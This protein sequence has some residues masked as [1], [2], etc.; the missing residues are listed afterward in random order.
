MVSLK[1]EN[2]SRYCT[3]LIHVC[4]NYDLQWTVGRSNILSEF[5][6]YIFFNFGRGFYGSFPT[7]FRKTPASCYKKNLNQFLVHCTSI[8]MSLESMSQIFKILF[9]TGDI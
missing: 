5:I 8:L 7:L 3:K 6:I 2:L 9:Q 1:C 4:K